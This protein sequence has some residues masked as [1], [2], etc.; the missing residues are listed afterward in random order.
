MRHL[1]GTLLT[2]CVTLCIGADLPAQDDRKPALG[3]DGSEVV[4]KE[5]GLS[6]ISKIREVHIEAGGT[7]IVAAPV[8]V[9]EWMGVCNLQ[10]DHGKVSP[11]TCMA[12]LALLERARKDKSKVE[13]IY[14][15]TVA[16]SDLTRGGVAGKPGFCPTQVQPPKIK[17]PELPFVVGPAVPTN[18]LLRARYEL[19]P[20]SIGVL[21]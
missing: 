17:N 7:V 12:W 2:A 3:R 18:P 15:T 16:F 8:F 21:P 4:R 20:L 10:T 14:D 1:T 11:P 9:R 13:F 5:A 6:C 19:P